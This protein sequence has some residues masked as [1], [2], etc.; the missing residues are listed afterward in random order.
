MKPKIRKILAACDGS[1]ESEEAFAAMMPIVRV[2]DP[3]VTVLYVFED[4][5][6]SLEPPRAVS[7]ACA[8]MQASR[9]HAHLALRKGKPAEE[10]LR[11]ART[12]EMDLIV[13]ATQGRTG[14]RRLV[15]GSVTEEVLRHAEVPVLVTRPGSARS[16]WSRMVVALDGSTRAESILQDV[17]PLACSLQASVDLVRAS[18]PPI[19]MTGLG[20]MPG[21]VIHED[22]LPYLRQLQAALV[23]KGIETHVAAPEGRAAS[24]ILQHAMKSGASL[25]CL[26]TH[27]RTGLARV[28]MGSIAEEIVRHASCPVLIRRTVRSE[29][30]PLPILERKGV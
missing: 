13:M 25:L 30:L 16:H 3:E 23:E 14:L 4:P 15:G 12:G 29:G 18:L 28:L 9:V 6:A 1:A 10:I 11:L 5:Q 21:V 26:A 19:T 27:G 2:D 20:E 22:P 7:Q 17:I 8:T 24:A